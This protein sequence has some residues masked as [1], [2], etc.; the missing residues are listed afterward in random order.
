M[1][2]LIR[3]SWDAQQ[4]SSAL[5]VRAE[6]CAVVCAWLRAASLQDITS[7]LGV[8]TSSLYILACTV[9]LRSV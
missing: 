9:L 1:R 8:E 4:T 5:I 2:I 3:P 6:T 7:A